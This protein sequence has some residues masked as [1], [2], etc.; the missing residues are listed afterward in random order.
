MRPCQAGAAAVTAE[1][2]SVAVALLPAAHRRP[3]T[4]HDGPWAHACS[5][6]RRNRCST[7][8][9][10]VELN[11]RNSPLAPAAITIATTSVVLASLDHLVVEHVADVLTL[12][13]ISRPI[14]PDGSTLHGPLG[15]IYRE[16][17]VAEFAPIDKQLAVFHRP[18]GMRWEVFALEVVVAIGLELHREAASSPSEVPLCARTVA[19]DCQL[20]LTQGPLEG[21]LAPIVLVIRLLWHGVPLHR[22]VLRDIE[23][24]LAEL[25]PIDR[26]H[27]FGERPPR[28]SLE[29]RAE[30]LTCRPQAH[31]EGAALPTQVVPTDQIR[32]LG[33]GCY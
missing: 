23:L 4:Y 14:A 27:P 15:S 21:C 5:V 30:E 12:A 28:L 29:L 33:H 17:E 16:L 1:L 13:P 10:F 31:I 22:L 8:K 9:H 25:A 3:S 24:V 32:L 26:N 6:T 18:M 20:L 7:R 2:V 11:L 19:D